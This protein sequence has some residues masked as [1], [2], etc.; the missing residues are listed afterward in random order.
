MKREIRTIKG[1]NVGGCCPG[2][3]D[4]PSDSYANRRSKKARSRDKAKEHRTARRI[5]TQKIKDGDYEVA[6]R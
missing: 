2:H 4:Y 1:H 5:V 3:D 6:V